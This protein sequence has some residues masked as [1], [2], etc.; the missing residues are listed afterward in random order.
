LKDKGTLLV[1]GLWIVQYQG[2]H[3]GDS[4]VVVFVN[5]RVLGG[6]NACTYVG[7]YAVQGGRIIAQVK[8]SFF[9]SDVQ[10]VLGLPGD[11]ELRLSANA[12]S[13]LI[14]GG[15]TLVGQPGLGIV[16]KLTKKTSL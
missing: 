8:I 13:D 12:S 11:A 15:M 4:G 16:V 6:D 3:G 1:E 7:D 2:L 14:E 9:R 10:S 5:G